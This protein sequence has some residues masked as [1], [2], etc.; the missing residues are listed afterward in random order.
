MRAVAGTNAS[1]GLG[2]YFLGLLFRT[3]F[4]AGINLRKISGQPCDELVPAL[5]GEGGGLDGANADLFV[6][7]HTPTE[8][9]LDD[10]LLVGREIFS[11]VDHGKRPRLHYDGL[12]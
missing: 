4:A 11:A 10:G 2:K 9:A 12:D 7:E 1:N 8:Q 6:F 5:S 3:G